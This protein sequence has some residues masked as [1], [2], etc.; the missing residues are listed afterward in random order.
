M[1]AATAARDERRLLRRALLRLAAVYA[2]VVLAVEAVL[3]AAT[4]AIMG[5]RL[6]SLARQ[7]VVA[8]WRDK[9]LEL[10]QAIRSHPLSSP[11]VDSA[12][13]AVATSVVLADGRFAVVDGRLVE[14][15]GSIMPA[16]T[17]MAHLP[18]T[19]ASPV[20]WRTFRLHGTLVLAGRRAYF[21]A[22]RYVGALISL[23]SL[24]PMV[25]ASRELSETEFELGAAS[26]ALVLPAALLLARRALRPLEAA[27]ERQRAF[28][29]DAAHELRTPLTVLRGNLSLALDGSE[30]AEARTHVSDALAETDRMARLVDDLSLLAR[31][32]S[33]LVLTRPQDMDLARVVAETVD[34]MRP[35]ALARGLSLTA[36]GADR[37]LVVRGDPD[38]LRQALT[39]LLDNAMKYTPSPG[40]VEVRLE[41][42][43]A[44]A[45]LSVRDTGPGVPREEVPRIFERFYRGRR[46]R[47]DVPGSGIG[48]AV[49]R[50]IVALH[51][52]RVEVAEADGGGAAFTIV[53]PVPREPSA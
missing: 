3:A 6:T 50:A 5:Y 25:D 34:R 9:R 27:L 39:A 36:F 23:V 22:G 24:A 33:G 51:G 4:Y 45:R 48:L 7:E 18:V 49:V 53:L 2:A 44:F 30:P 43:G 29:H 28:V 42:Q 8:E 17:A 31:M 11:S 12:P 46:H 26:L 19:A 32:D 16:V 41:R 15:P 40:R 35:L 10:L 52:G 20:T 21:R 1:S 38:R 47:A 37:R 14:A 13:E